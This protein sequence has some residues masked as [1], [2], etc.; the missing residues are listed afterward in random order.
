M[1]AAYLVGTGET[2][3]VQHRNEDISWNEEAQNV[4]TSD[5]P[6][7]SAICVD[8][9]WYAYDGHSRLEWGDEG[10]WNRN[11]SHAP[12]RHQELLCGSLTSTRHGVVHADAHRGSQQDC[13]YDIVRDQEVLLVRGVHV[14][15]LDSPLV[16]QSDGWETCLVTPI[17]LESLPTLKMKTLIMYMS[18]TKDTAAMWHRQPPPPTIIM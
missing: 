16:K 6:V 3:S 5:E 12:V 15:G 10:Q 13:E 17:S 8:F 7:L 11:T 2:Q 18:V 4:S 1:A 9:C 14:E